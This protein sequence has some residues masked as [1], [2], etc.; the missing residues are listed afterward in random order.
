MALTF[1]ETALPGVVLVEPDV[2]PDERGYFTET[3]HAEKYQAGGIVC[4]FRQD[5]RSQSRKNVVRGLHYQLKQPQAKLIYVVQGEILDVALDIR[6]GSPTFGQWTACILSAE[7]R[8]Q[9]FIP[10]GFAHGFAILSDLADVAYKCSDLRA[11]GDEYG[12]LWND[13]ALGIDWQIDTPVVS[14]KDATCPTLAEIPTANL[15]VFSV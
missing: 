1:T 3:Y 6:K 4:T 5:N 15:P 14:E 2:F 11:A 7:N 8:C 10:V 13:P 9:L 12:L